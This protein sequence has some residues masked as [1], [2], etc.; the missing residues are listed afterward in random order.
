MSAT[1]RNILVLNPFGTDRYDDVITKM[2]DPVKLP[3]TDFLVNHLE[4][5]P[6][7]IDYWTYKHFVVS[8]VIDTV[9]RAE[10]DGYSGVFV[11]CGYEPGVRAAREVVDIPVVGALIPTVLVAHQLGARFSVFYNSRM[12]GINSWDI[13]R[14]YGLTKQCVSLKSIDLS[15]REILSDPGMVDKQV[16]KQSYKAVEEGAEVIILACTIEAAY[17]TRNVPA[18]LAQMV[19]LNCNIIAFKYL[20]ML[21]ELHQK[22]GLKVSRMGY[23]ASPKEEN[24]EDFEAFRALYGYE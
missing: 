4:K 1:Q 11:A 21:V 17:F 10:K 16:I 22:T 8:D 20:E 9:Y 6:D 15:L 3:D 13:L 24:R 5:G 18:N 12:S 7:Y 19:Y 23:Y 14:S 2:L